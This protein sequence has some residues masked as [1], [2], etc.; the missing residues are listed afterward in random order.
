LLPD[1]AARD[2]ADNTLRAALMTGMAPRDA[3]ENVLDGLISKAMAEGDV[4]YLDVA[5]QVP[6]LN[7]KSQEVPMGSRIWA[8]EKIAA[9]RASLESQKARE[10]KAAADNQKLVLEQNKEAS[11]AEAVDILHGGRSLPETAE[12][13]E[14]FKRKAVE[15]TRKGLLD[16]KLVPEL[17]RMREEAVAANLKA[18]ERGEVIGDYGSVAHE[19]ATQFILGGQVATLSKVAE[20]YAAPSM[21]PFRGAAFKTWN[22]WK[23]AQEVESDYNLKGMKLGILND[24]NIKMLGAEKIASIESYWNGSI[25]AF[26]KERDK[27][28]QAITVIEMNEFA[29]NLADQVIARYS[30][31]P[32]KNGDKLAPAKDYVES[33][34][35]T[36]RS[37]LQ[38]AKDK[39]EQNLIYNREID[40]KVPTFTKD[41]I[42]LPK[43]LKDLGFD[44]W[45]D[46]AAK[47]YERHVAA[48]TGVA[49]N[50]GSADAIAAAK[51]LNEMVRNKIVFERQQ[52]GTDQERARM[53]QASLAA[54]PRVE[55]L[56]PM[57]DGMPIN[58]ISKLVKNGDAVIVRA[59]G[60]VRGY[61]QGIYL[62]NPEAGMQAALELVQTELK[63]TR[64]PDPKP[65]TPNK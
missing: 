53:G 30:N 50:S 42:D 61:A 10:A 52:A 32:D 35:D 51:V 31:K 18:S 62:K 33:Y 12:V 37:A 48:I 9:A 65:D 22:D 3:Y 34:G 15:L 1:V 46:E 11:L 4:G 56:M 41:I 43:N 40:A 2:V 54:Y 28:G 38:N 7:D 27:A 63:A 6:T 25:A 20:M 45:G 5:E 24:P 57:P 55:A 64:R 16:P 39:E 60:K 14:Q 13:Y 17:D 59:D 23:K 36:V 26:K 49:E 58:V 21:A 19:E 29:S 47:R 8:Q 44:T